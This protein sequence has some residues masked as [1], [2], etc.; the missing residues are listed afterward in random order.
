MF[1]NVF[2]LPAQGESGENAEPFA[3]KRER[4]Q[5]AECIERFIQ[6]SVLGDQCAGSA[7]QL[8]DR[9][10]SNLQQHF[11]RHQDDRLLPFTT[12]CSSHCEPGIERDASISLYFC[13]SLHLPSPSVI[14][15]D[16]NL[17]LRS[18]RYQFYQVA[19][20]CWYRNNF[21][22][23]CVCYVNDINSFMLI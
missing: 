8:W 11:L 19:R 14:A 1:L 23:L 4:H 16:D 5:V 13:C 12:H 22:I 15:L 20:K 17:H 21:I 9:F 3:M 18:M 7:P 2:F 6:V 10:T